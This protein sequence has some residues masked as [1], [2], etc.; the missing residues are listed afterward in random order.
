MLN[1]YKLFLPISILIILSTKVSAGFVLENCKNIDT[2]KNYKNKIFIVS[3][4]GYKKILHIDHKEVTV[5]RMY[6]LESYYSNQAIGTSEN[7]KVEILVDANEKIVE[8]KYV[9]GGTDTYSC[10]KL[11]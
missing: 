7:K 10:S 8:I 6:D 3:D 1:F 4:G 5:L 11:R 2:G 9:S